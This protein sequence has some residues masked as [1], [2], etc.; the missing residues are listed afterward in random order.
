MTRRVVRLECGV[1]TRVL[2]TPYALSFGTLSQVHSVWV[3]AQCGDGACGVGEAVPLPG[4][5]GGSL[6]DVESIV[7]RLCKKFCGRTQAE[8]LEKCRTASRKAPFA[9]SAVATAVEFSDFAARVRPEEVRVPLVYP[10]S[11]G[12]KGASLLCAME[13]AVAAGFTEF[14]MKIGRDVEG[15]AMAAL[16]ALERARSLGSRI[17]FDANQG[18]DRH[19]ALALCRAFDMA[20]FGSELRWVEQPLARDDWDGMAS[21]VRQTD[22]PLMLDEPVY[23]EEDISRA[24]DVGAAAV[25][26]KLCKHPGLSACV[27]L[28]EMA[29][30][31]GLRVTLGN[32]V[33]T[34]IGNV[35]ESLA[36]VADG[37]PFCGALE[38]NGFTRL[39]HPM[40]FKQVRQEG[41]ALVMEGP[42]VINDEALGELKRRSEFFG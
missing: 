15:D 16:L 20:G 11:A 23:S 26:L 35:A 24:V 8:I 37:K 31:A 4:Y 3:F 42:P 7:R 29:A 38:C 1:G 19:D 36:V 34:D 10:L 25:K 27:S 33:S 5:G 22:V 18:Y 32:G 6:D 17:R 28:A 14:K 30:E 2:K 39:R 12:T 40:L 21:L 13:D 41:G 9:A